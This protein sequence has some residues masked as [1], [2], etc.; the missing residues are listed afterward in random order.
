MH[1][2]E[3]HYIDCFTISRRRIVSDQTDPLSH[4]LIPPLVR[5][6]YVL[7]GVDFKGTD[8]TIQ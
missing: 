5:L 8:Y 2:D 1:G 4:G 7:S 3:F 6:S